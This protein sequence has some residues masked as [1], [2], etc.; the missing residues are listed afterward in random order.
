MEKHE[1]LQQAAMWH[2]RMARKALAAALAEEAASGRETRLL[3]D[4][5]AQLGVMAGIDTRANVGR[6]VAEP[7]REAA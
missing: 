3:A 7:E 2:I 4:M 6:P 5:V 1:K